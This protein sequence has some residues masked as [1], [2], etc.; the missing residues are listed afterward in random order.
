MNA[1]SIGSDSPRWWWPSA[2][3]G[4]V[5]SAAIAAIL[6]LPANSSTP[7]GGTTPDSP[8]PASDPWFSTYDPVVGRQCFA[9]RAGWNA[10]L[11]H[12]NPRCG[13]SPVIQRPAGTGVRRPGLDSR[14]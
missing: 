12:E 5:G 2:A 10:S 3:V 6:V 7:P 14:P 11:A 9:L 1:Y 8:A 4:A 13:H